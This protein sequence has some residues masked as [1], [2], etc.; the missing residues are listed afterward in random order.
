[1]DATRA[2][3]LVNVRYVMEAARICPVPFYW[4][5][6]TYNFRIA[7]MITGTLQ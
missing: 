4:I 2:H 7:L 3:K 6:P 5:T 1:M